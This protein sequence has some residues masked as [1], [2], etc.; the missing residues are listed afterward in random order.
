MSSVS[1]NH[2]YWAYGPDHGTPM[3]DALAEGRR[4]YALQKAIESQGI[5]E[6][7][8]SILPRAKDFERFLKGEPAEDTNGAPLDGR[9]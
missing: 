8:G 6:P 4:A 5:D 3:I 2:P 9:S 1:E 7:A